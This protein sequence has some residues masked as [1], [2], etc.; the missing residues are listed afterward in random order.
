MRRNYERSFNYIEDIRTVS[1]KAARMNK[2]KAIKKNILIE[3][4]T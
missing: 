4:L 3:C 1:M 2:E